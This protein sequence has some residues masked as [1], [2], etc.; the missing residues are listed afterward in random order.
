MKTQTQI[1]L[2]RLIERL[3][4]EETLSGAKYIVTVW[5]S[6]SRTPKPMCFLTSSNPNNL[7][8]LGTGQVADIVQDE[9]GHSVSPDDFELD[10]PMTVAEW[11]EEYGS[12][13]NPNR[14]DI[15]AYPK[16]PV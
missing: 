3:I 8:G 2:R 6:G 5:E 1:K 4:R 14:V 13:A 12:H 9:L 7:E 15:N 10:S 16:I 11:M